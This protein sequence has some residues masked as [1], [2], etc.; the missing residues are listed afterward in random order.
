MSQRGTDSGQT[1]ARPG[2]CLTRSALWGDHD[3]RGFAGRIVFASLSDKLFEQI[4]RKVLAESQSIHLYHPELI[5]ANNIRLTGYRL[6]PD[7]VIRQQDMKLN[8]T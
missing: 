6:L 3:A 2:V 1:P 4:A 8:E 7:G 5:H